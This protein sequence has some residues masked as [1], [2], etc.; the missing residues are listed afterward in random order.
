MLMRF[1]TI[2]VFLKF[3]LITIFMVE[4]TVVD[5]YALSKCYKLLLNNA[6]PLDN[7]SLVS[8]R[9]LWIFVIVFV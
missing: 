5:F 6:K 2:K 3:Y 4:R 9:E 7:F 8:F 1:T